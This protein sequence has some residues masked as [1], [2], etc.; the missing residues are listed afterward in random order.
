MTAQFLINYFKSQIKSNKIQ[1]DNLDWAQLVFD[2]N[3]EVVVENEHGTQ[4]PVTDLS[5]AEMDIFYDNI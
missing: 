5:K 3:G 2:E 4:F 1:L